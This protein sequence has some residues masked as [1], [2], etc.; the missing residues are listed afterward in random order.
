MPNTAGEWIFQI[1]TCKQ[2]GET[3]EEIKNTFGNCLDACIY[4]EYFEN[5]INHPNYSKSR[6]RI[7]FVYNNFDIEIIEPE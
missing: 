7:E 4:D 6:S 1:I 2:Y 5:Y 3:F